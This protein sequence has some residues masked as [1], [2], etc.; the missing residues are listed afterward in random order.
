MF[1]CKCVERKIKNCVT[2]SCIGVL[3]N[4][5]YRLRDSK[6]RPRLGR[7]EVLVWSSTKLKKNNKPFAEHDPRTPTASR[8]KK[9]KPLAK[10]DPRTPTPTRLKINCLQNM[11]RA[12]LRLRG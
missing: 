3:M 4:K 11:T 8:L 5:N 2:F 6:S 1:W 9:D 7:A 12:R 10:H